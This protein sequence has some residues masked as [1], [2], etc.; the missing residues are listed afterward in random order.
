VHEEADEEEVVAVVVAVATPAPALVG[1]A[2]LA[3]GASDTA[4]VVSTAA[5]EEEAVVVD[6][7]RGLLR[8][9]C[10]FL[11]DALGGIMIG[12]SMAFLTLFLFIGSLLECRQLQLVGTEQI[13]SVCV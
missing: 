12:V 2:F 13:T 6:V 9:L 11:C 1:R 3:F 10:I 7:R 5:A 4:T 8:R